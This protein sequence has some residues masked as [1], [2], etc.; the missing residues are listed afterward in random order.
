MLTLFSRRVELRGFDSDGARQVL[1]IRTL[2]EP[3]NIGPQDAVLV[4]REWDGDAGAAVIVLRR[5]QALIPASAR[6]VIIVPDE[7]HYVSDGDVISLNVKRP[8]IRVLYRRNSPHNHFLMTERCNHYC[9]MC[10]QPPR[11]I[12]DDWVVNEILEAIPLLAA[13]TPEIGLTGGEPTLLGDRF[14]SVLR[15]LRHNLP[16]SAVHILSNGRRFS[17]SEFARRYAEISHPDVMLGIPIYAD[18]SQLHDYIVQSEGAFD[19]TIRGILNLKALKQKVEIRI[20]IHKLNYERLPDLAE[21]VCR[22]LAFVDHV[23]LMALEVTGFARA[24]LDALWIDPFDYRN[25]LRRAALTLRDL[26]LRT[27]VYNHQLCT[28]DK[29]VWPLAVRSISDWKNEYLP[30]CT[31]CGEHKRCGGF[32]AT[33]SRHSQH[34]RAIDA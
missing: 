18:V 19:E 32:F 27:S 28:L 15:S 34:I 22:N 6:R 31:R 12:D 21:F 17:D 29:R 23:A 11:D 9:L 1:R 5:L 4:D 10:S 14:L 30:E 33:G 8:A 25:E 16:T 3:S 7:F 24:N 20:V 26:G 2:S 13:D